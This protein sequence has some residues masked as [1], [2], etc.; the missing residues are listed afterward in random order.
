MNLRRRIFVT[1]Q[2]EGFHRY[3]AAPDEVAFLRQPHRHMFHV[4]VQ[5]VVFHDDRELEFIMVKRQLNDIVASVAA[6][7]DAG[8]C[9]QIAECILKALAH[10]L[11]FYIGPEERDP[12]VHGIAIRYRQCQ[13]T[14]SEDGEN[15]A[16]VNN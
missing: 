9:E 7:E 11:P 14:V 1:T 10:R 16:I 5:I 6:R 8:S 13:V 15:G 4:E 2:F 12:N 3:A